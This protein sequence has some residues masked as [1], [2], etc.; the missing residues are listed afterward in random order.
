VA[1]GRRKGRAR[2][3]QPQRRCAGCRAQRPKAELLRIVAR[4]GAAVPDP[5]AVL[6]GRGAYLCRKEACAQAAA[7]GRA[8]ARA[9][10]GRA[11]EPSLEELRAWVGAAPAR[12]APGPAAPG[13]RA[14]RG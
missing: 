9:L 11:R 6:P 8:L 7:K 5:R 1:R 3:A 13:E 12:E 10:K 2:P 14:G 4:E